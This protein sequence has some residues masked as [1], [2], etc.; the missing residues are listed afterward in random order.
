MKSAR[1]HENGLVAALDRT[2]STGTFWDKTRQLTP[3]DNFKLAGPT[4]MPRAKT[5]GVFPA[6]RLRNRVAC[7][8]FHFATPTVNLEISNGE[9]VRL[10]IR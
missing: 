9:P 6:I 2:L 7:P 3:V 4:K 8:P 10:F 1:H 5:A